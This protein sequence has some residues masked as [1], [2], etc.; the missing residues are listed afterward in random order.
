MAFIADNFSPVGGFHGSDLTTVASG[1]AVHSYIT[2]D[3]LTVVK[4]A[5]YF[6]DLRDNLYHGDIIYVGSTQL[7]ADSSDNEY[8]IIQVNTAPRSPLTTNVTVLAA[9][10]NAT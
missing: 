10:I 9:D 3:T 5:G 6:N 8:T 1:V 7:D 2:A 4:T